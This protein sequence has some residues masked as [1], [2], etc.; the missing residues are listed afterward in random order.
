LTT[1]ER[2]TRFLEQ[3]DLLAAKSKLAEERITSFEVLQQ[4][5]LN[6]TLR[7]A[8]V[9]K[10]TEKQGDVEPPLGQKWIGSKLEKYKEEDIRK[11]IKKF[12]ESLKPKQKPSNMDDAVMKHL[13]AV[14]F[15]E[16]QLLIFEK[17]QVFSLPSLRA[18]IKDVGK[19]SA[20]QNELQDGTE[21]DGKQISGTKAAGDLMKRLI[22]SL[23]PAP[24]KAN[25]E[26]K[27]YLADNGFPE[28][29]MAVFEKSG[30]VSLQT[31]RAVIKDP[32]AKKALQDDLE[33]GGEF[34]GNMLAGSKASAALF[35]DLKLNDV[36]S[37]IEKGAAPEPA[38]LDEKQ[39]KR[40]QQIKAAVTEV[41]NLRQAEADKTKGL[42]T[43]VENKVKEQLKEI[44]T[45]VDSE[46]LLKK[47]TGTPAT[48]TDLNA[49]LTT[50]Q[51][52][53]TSQA[54]KI[55]DDATAGVKN[56]EVPTGL[57]VANNLR[58]GMLITATGIYERTGSD[59]VK[60]D[61]GT[62]MPGP[63]Q[64]VN[65]NYSSESSYEYA[66][67]TINMS[68]S[69]DA[70]S[71]SAIGGFTSSSGIG[72]VSLG[73]QYAKGKMESKAKAVAL[74]TGYAVLV[75]ESTI[76]APK[77]VITMPRD[78]MELSLAAVDKLNQIAKAP[79][80]EEKDKDK[81]LKRKYARDFIEN[82][83]THVFRSVT[84]GGRYSY[85][86]RAETTPRMPTKSPTRHSARPGRQQA[87]GVLGFSGKHFSGS[88]APTSTATPAP[89]QP[90]P[91]LRHGIKRRQLL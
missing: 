59:L 39:I 7:G 52:A 30:A 62:G 27:K 1:E 26:L 2:L 35:D 75:Q 21:V 68:S 76:I 91:R 64:E 83:G 29:Q 5:L 38:M 28:E 65:T 19:S 32:D 33:K 40:Y 44:L 54:D 82:F 16:E 31:L 24:P 81:K 42:A 84:L 13:L 8:L 74:R 6:E 67:K 55:F 34:D 79:E 60:G 58:R 48:V 12:N 87:R 46:V 70:T 36:E 78:K 17:N 86:A 72:A 53:L 50:V 77:A 85:V 47:L 4:I 49:Q 23:R 66:Q 18:V 45:A 41:D 3:E 51:N 10:F 69:T 88:V 43:A 9:K 80:A 63:Y 20:L 37:K 61:F 11:A 57:A 90:Q 73:F 89:V 25:D 22:D 14:G 15:S 71:N 56:Y